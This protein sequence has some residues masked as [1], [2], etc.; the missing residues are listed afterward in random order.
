MFWRGLIAGAGV[1][2]IG[3]IFFPFSQKEETPVKE[4]ELQDISG[5]INETQVIYNQREIPTSK[6]IYDWDYREARC[7]I[8]TPNDNKIEKKDKEANK[9]VCGTRHIF[10]IRHG[11]YVY[12]SKSDQFQHLTERG[13]KQAKLTG[14]RLRDLGFHW[15]RCIVS[16]MTRARETADIICEEIK[17]DKAKAEYTDLLREGI[18]FMPE[19]R[20]EWKPPHKVYN[21]YKI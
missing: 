3:A 8:K 16:T 2:T 7:A 19:P 4:N 21:L 15:D 6:W 17:F 11:E 20:T 10:L 5:T 18:P 14:Q 9:H 1:G 13:R 12:S